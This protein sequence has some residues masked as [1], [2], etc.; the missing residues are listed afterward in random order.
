MGHDDD[1]RSALA[2]TPP[3]PS[4]VVLGPFRRFA[5]S[6]AGSGMVLLGCAVVALWWANS[7]W[8]EGYAS[9]W[10]GDLTVAVGPFTVV[11]TLSHWIDDGLMALFFLLVGLEIKREILVGELS[12]L[13]RAV[14]PVAAAIGGMVLPAMIYVLA[15]V[16]SPSDG[17]DAAA[18]RGWGVPMATDIAFALGVLALLGKR[19]PTPVRVFLASLAIADDIGAL[20]VIALFYTDDLNAVY[21]GYALGVVGVLVGANLARVRAPAFYL[22]V[23]GVLVYVMGHSGIHATIAGVLT[24]AAVPVTSRVD[25]GSFMTTTR[26]ALDAFERAQHAKAAPVDISPRQN[27]AALAISLNA[28]HVRPP[29]LR[30]EHALAPWVNFAVLP[31]FA[32]ANAGVHLGGHF[33]EMITR[34]VTVGVALGLLLGKPLGIVGACV[35]AVKCR[36]AELPR[37]AG[38]GEIVGVGFLGGIGFTMA[39]FISNLAFKTDADLLTEAKL[40]ILLA[41]MGASVVGLTI[42]L[43]CARAG[44]RP[45]E[46][47]FLAD[48]GGAGTR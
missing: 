36:A 35:I 9:L 37:G 15:Q 8:S 39:I 20:I 48:A 21:M 26:H 11:G 19:I 25:A 23:G 33:S 41:S 34:P 6:A 29:L 31:L 47:P 3:P 44:D 14:L 22:V 4:D 17:I 10:H 43:L 42:L 16:W 32:V 1:I 40:G 38:W 24:A 27:A 28:T 5:R 46:P 13:R 45:P 2:V 12:S 18:M 30:M 7:A